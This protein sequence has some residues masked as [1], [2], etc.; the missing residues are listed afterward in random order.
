MQRIEI[1]TSDLKHVDIDF[2][3]ICENPKCNNNKRTGFDNLNTAKL[4]YLEQGENFTITCTSVG[5]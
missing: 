2:S 1:S 4:M 3:Y 5:I